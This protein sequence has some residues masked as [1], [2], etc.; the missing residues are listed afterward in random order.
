MTV[1]ADI[2]R[3]TLGVMGCLPELPPEFPVD[4]AENAGN[5]IHGM[6][7]FEMF[8]GAAFYKDPR[9]SSEGSLGNFVDYV[10]RECSHLIVTVANFIKLGDDNGTRYARFQDFLSK[11]EVPI[12]IFGLGAQSPTQDLEA[13]TLPSEA[14]ELFKFLGDST[15]AVGVRGHFK[16]NV[17][18]HFA[19]VTNTFVT[20]CPSFFS[21]PAAFDALRRNV[22]LIPQGDIAYNGTTY[23]EASEKRLL[24]QAIQQDHYLVEPVNKFTTRFHEELQDGAS[25][26]EIPWFLKGPVKNGTLTRRQVE[27]YFRDR[28]RLF[29]KPEPWYEF[30]ASKVSRTYGTRF[31][32]NMA[33]ILS[34]VPALWLTH[35]SR[36]EELT[37]FLRVPRV[38]KEE[39]IELT[40]DQLL[41]HIDYAPMFAALDG[42][43]DN[44]NSYLLTH[45]LPP[46]RK[47]AICS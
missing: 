4:M 42:L 41:A 12:V 16:A 34:G 18:E 8:A 20:G 35:D 5:T 44:F 37:D 28:F 6:A 30:N 33:S 27:T 45:G 32:V 1:D 11:I 39:A 10:N 43:F 40:V 21:R 24:I 3:P 23:H 38:N 36:T 31:H 22:D 15:E 13:T 9:F 19:G 47:P 46:T 7:P 17:F 26:P 14:I 2:S 25:E 29:R